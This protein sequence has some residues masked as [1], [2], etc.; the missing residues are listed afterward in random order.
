MA[1]DEENKRAERIAYRI[2]E[3]HSVLDSLYESITDRDFK[4]SQVDIKFLISE[5]RITLK[6]TEDDDF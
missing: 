3:Y 4:K 5:L 2:S 1:R 6:A